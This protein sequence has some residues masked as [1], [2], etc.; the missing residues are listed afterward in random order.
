MKTSG[1]CSIAS[2]GCDWTHLQ[3]NQLAVCRHFVPGSAIKRS[4]CFLFPDAAP[5]FEKERDTSG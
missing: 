5:L 4:A 3:N 1:G 2:S